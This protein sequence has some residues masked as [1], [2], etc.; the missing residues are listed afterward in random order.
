MHLLAD[1][2][3]HVWEAIAMQATALAK[4]I[5]VTRLVTLSPGMRVVDGIAQLIRHDIS[6]APVIEPDG[7]YRG[8]FSEKCCMQVL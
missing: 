7:T 1:S 4:D 2:R 6:G 5:M 3:A 8:V